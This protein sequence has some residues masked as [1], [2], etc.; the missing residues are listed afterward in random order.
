MLLTHTEAYIQ[1]SAAFLKVHCLRRIYPNT[2]ATVQDT[3]QSLLL[4]CNYKLIGDCFSTL[5]IILAAN[6]SLLLK[7]PFLIWPLTTSFLLRAVH[8]H[9]FS[10]ILCSGHAE[11]C[12]S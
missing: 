5:L 11:H 6:K 10:Q 1:M 2:A 9:P 4:E 12:S 8:S 7:N 3:F